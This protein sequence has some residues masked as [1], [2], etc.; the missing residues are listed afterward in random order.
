MHRGRRHTASSATTNAGTVVALRRGTSTRRARPIRATGE[1]TNSSCAFGADGP[2]PPIGISYLSDCSSGSSLST[3]SS[4]S[5]S[6]MSSSSTDSQDQATIGVTSESVSVSHKSP[7]SRG[8][9]VPVSIQISNGP[10]NTRSRRAPISSRLRSVDTVDTG[11]SDNSAASSGPVR[12]A[13][14]ISSNP[15]TTRSGRRRSSRTTNRTATPPHSLNDSVQI[16]GMQ[17]PPVSTIRLRLGRTLTQPPRANRPGSLTRRTLISSRLNP[18]PLA[19]QEETVAR[20][21]AQSSAAMRRSRSAA[22]TADLHAALVA[23]RRPPGSA[24]DGEDDCVICLCEKSNRSVVLPCMHT[25]CFDCIHRW[26]TINPSC[27]LCKRLAQRVIHSVLSDTEFTELLVSDLQA[28]RNSRRVARLPASFDLEEEI[29]FAHA[30]TAAAAAAADDVHTQRGSSSVPQRQSHHHYHYHLNPP[31]VRLIDYWDGMGRDEASVTSLFLPSATMHS[32]GSMSRSTGT[33]QPRPNFRWNPEF[34]PLV[35]SSRS[36]LTNLVNNALRRRNSSLL[37]GLLLRQLVYI[38]GFESVPV[39]Q[40]PVLERDITPNFLATNE[41]QRQRLQ[42]FV[43]RDLRV[44]APWL[45]YRSSSSSTST[46][47]N[48]N[49]SNTAPI[50][51]D[52]PQAG[53]AVTA[54]LICGAPGLLADTPELD[55]ITERV[56][57][58][59]TSVPMTNADAL[60]QLLISFPA[61]CPPLVPAIYLTHFCSE[62]IQFAR[63]SGTLEQ[64]DYAVCLYRRHSPYSSNSGLTEPSSTT[65]LYPATRTTR[66]DPRLAVYMGSACWPRLRP[67][68][69]EPQGLITHPL[70]NWLLQRLFVHSVSG[71][72]HPSALPGTGE[73][74]LIVP[75]P[76]VFQ[77]S[78]T[79]C[80]PHCSRLSS[81][82]RALLEA[83]PTIIRFRSTSFQSE[84]IQMSGRRRVVVTNGNDSTNEGN[85]TSA[86]LY[87]NR[88]VYQRILSELIDQARFSDALASYFSSYRTEGVTSLDQ[89]NSRANS[90]STTISELRSR[91]SSRMNLVLGLFGDL[92]S[93]LSTENANTPPSSPVTN[94]SGIDHLRPALDKHSQ[95]LRRLSGLLLLFTARVP[96][97]L[98]AERDED[99]I[100]E[101]IH[102]P[103]MPM[104]VPPVTPLSTPS[105]V[106]DLTVNT[107]NQDSHSNRSLSRSSVQPRSP[108]TNSGSES[109][110][111]LHSDWH[112]LFRPTLFSRTSVNGSSQSTAVPESGV[113]D[114]SNRTVSNLSDSPIHIE[115]GSGEDH[116]LRP[117]QA[118][119]TGSGQ[120]QTETNVSSPL[121]AP[122]ILGLDNLDTGSFQLETSLSPV[123]TDLYWRAPNDPCVIISSDSSPA[124]S[125]DETVP[126]RRSIVPNPSDPLYAIT[127][128]ESDHGANSSLR[129]TKP[130]TVSPTNI[131]IPSGP[132]DSTDL[133]TVQ[134]NTS[135]LSLDSQ[136]GPPLPS[137]TSSFMSQLITNVHGQE[138]PMDV[139]EK[140]EDLVA[141]PES[142]E[143]C[144]VPSGTKRPSSS[145]QSDPPDSGSYPHAPKLSRSVEP[146]LVHFSLRPRLAFVKSHGGHW[147]TPHSPRSLH[148]YHPRR[149]RYHDHTRSRSPIVLE[150]SESD[151][152]LL[153]ESI[154]VYSDSSSCSSSSSSTSSS[155]SSS[156]SSSQSRPR[157]RSCSP[158]VPIPTER[159]PRRDSSTDSS[160]HHHRRR[161]RRCH[162][163]RHHCHG[164]R[165]HRKQGRRSKYHKRSG[166]KHH[167]HHNEKHD[168]HA[169]RRH[170]G[171][172]PRSRYYPRLRMVRRPAQTV[173]LN[174]SASPILISDEDNELNNPP[175]LDSANTFELPSSSHSGPTSSVA[176]IVSSNAPRQSS[177]T[178]TSTTCVPVLSDEPC[179]SYSGG[180]DNR[181]RS[182]VGEAAQDSLSPKTE[183]KSKPSGSVTRSIFEP[184][185]LN[186]FYQFIAELETNPPSVGPRDSEPSNSIDHD[187]QGPSEQPTESSADPPT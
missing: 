133:L 163:H 126:A 42:S 180:A 78:R 124:S 13:L 121:N 148:Y 152:E 8:R 161:H 2:P 1:N 114:L 61:L 82:S 130:E 129:Q 142:S 147:I 22:D 168:K 158:P 84:A 154:H 6:S 102:T 177:T 34:G 117:D 165:K 174:S 105:Q 132:A 149:R 172:S 138:E 109:N 94:R 171:L 46:T 111:L 32:V 43:R 128:D 33:D 170:P 115:Q 19:A 113:L 48:A 12:C 166:S 27:P 49:E 91:A 99:V 51:P 127:D 24:S 74:P 66:R 44:L 62:V 11:N 30:A 52:E 7:R 80:H 143:N 58:H 9:T 5:S 119:Q 106:I 181:G 101:L 156:S 175:V 56:V 104:T 159:R 182:E 116:V 185:N 67:G 23:A 95:A 36:F 153:R 85:M 18:T 173:Q 176:T 131:S 53:S 88:L 96:S 125:D 112:F 50:T 69:A 141:A 40:E 77:Y 16:V 45:A 38:F 10:G 169:K 92:I 83:V 150:S 39:A 14:P 17:Q 140:P 167:H 4:T 71:A 97:G 75:E 79:P 186:E 184:S 25:F 87:P 86:E 35:E 103:L 136:V 73:Y 63:Y 160:R 179:C 157:E 59:F 65:T 139:D 187:A 3:S 81:L 118:Q 26:L 70:I 145:M 72:T 178:K 110:R 107:P 146:S 108:G 37:D 89:R 54:P 120:Q 134:D 68:F 41:A 29:L 20:T 57:N 28:Q 93:E 122:D 144:S 47:S 183:T 98:R 64:Y 55:M 151:C 162:C 60:H 31:P 155:R 15:V 164:C 76:L 90:A 21:P 135:R 100:S 137:Y 123:A